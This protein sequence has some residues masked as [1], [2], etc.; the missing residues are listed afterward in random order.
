MVAIIQLT[1]NEIRITRTKKHT[2]REKQKKLTGLPFFRYA[3]AIVP[4]EVLCE[5]INQYIFCQ[6][7]APDSAGGAYNALPPP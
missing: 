7:S 3:Y 5:A 6:S 1:F 2:Q 4:P